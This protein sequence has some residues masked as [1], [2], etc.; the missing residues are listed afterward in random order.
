MRPDPCRSGYHYCRN[1]N[2]V[3]RWYEGRPELWVV[4]VRGWSVAS[5]DKGCATSMRLVKRITDWDATEFRRLDTEVRRRL[6]YSHDDS[7][8][9][10]RWASAW[11]AKYLDKL[12]ADN[13]YERWGDR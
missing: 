8:L 7:P 6:M 9:S 1:I 10:I 11:C 2:D 12:L 3:M 13:G 5:R 4:E